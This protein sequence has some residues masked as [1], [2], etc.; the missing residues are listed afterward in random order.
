MAKNTIQ[1]KVRLRG[2]YYEF[3]KDFARH[4][5]TKD[6][7]DNRSAALRYI[8]EYVR[9]R[10]ALTDNALLWLYCP[11]PAQRL[12]ETEYYSNYDN[13]NDAMVYAFVAPEAYKFLEKY[14]LTKRDY[15][16]KKG[17]VVKSFTYPQFRGL[18]RNVVY[19]CINVFMYEMLLFQMTE[20][21]VFTLKALEHFGG[22]E[23][24]L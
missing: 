4:F 7:K 9:L 20:G 14:A 10:D 13:L 23:V 22:V 18:L 16:N 1:L 21:R 2:M 3:I 19:Q 11:L 17:S 12:R 15:V 24:E 8:I 6:G 5:K